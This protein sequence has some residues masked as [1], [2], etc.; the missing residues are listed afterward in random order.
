MLGVAIKMFFF[1][2]NSLVVCQW[3]MY[4][5]VIYFVYIHS[6]LMIEICHNSN[7]DDYDDYDYDDDNDD[8]D[9]GDD[10]GN[11]DF[12]VILPCIM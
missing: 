10:V 5:K 4:C 8:G 11:V 12:F 3:L 2:L 7:D 6:L 9:D 1:C